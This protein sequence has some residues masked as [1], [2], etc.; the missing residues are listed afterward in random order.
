MLLI[1]S[2]TSGERV[3]PDIQ[4]DEFERNPSELYLENFMAFGNLKGSFR[5]PFWENNP[6]IVVG[7]DLAETDSLVLSFELPDS[8]CVG[9]PFTVI[10][11]STGSGLTYS[12][13]I[14]PISAAS[15]DDPT[16]PTPT[17]TAEEPIGIHTI[18]VTVNN[19]MSGPETQNF[20]LYINKAPWSMLLPIENGCEV[21]QLTPYINV[22]PDLEFISSISWN[23]EGGIPSSSGMFFPTGIQYSS[24]GTYSV[25]VIVENECGTTFDERTFYVLEPP[26]PSYVFPDTVFI[27]E[28]FTPANNTTGDH[29]IFNWTIVPAGAVDM[30]SP[31]SSSPSFTVNGPEGIYYVTVTAQ[32]YECGPNE[33]FFDL[34]IEGNPTATKEEKVPAHDFTLYPIYPNPF[35][36]ETTIRFSAEAGNVLDLGIYTATG[37]LVYSSSKYY[38]AGFH[39]IPITRDLLG[40]VPGIY[41]YRIVFG[42]QQASSV[43]MLQW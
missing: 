33:A 34:Y 22:D 31:T 18:S 27:G 16:S 11:N 40:G 9:Q 35:E 15:I 29:L 36:H 20:S 25:T 5:M 32:S 6:S 38:P 2:S 24:T 4:S 21:L 12:W 3:R 23:F 13:S 19:P 42:A 10:N 17:F 37:Q 43:I 7:K 8:I 41:I 1:H 14:D 30:S 28:T 39:E 26:N